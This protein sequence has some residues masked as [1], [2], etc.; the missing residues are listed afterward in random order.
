MEYQELIE[1]RQS[2]RKF[3]KRELSRAQIQEIRDFYE[4]EAGRLYP[5]IH[6]ELQVFTG[7][8]KFRL[9]GVAGYRGN[10]FFAPAYVV[11]FSEQADYYMENAGYITEDLILK[12]TDMELDNCWL[13]VPDAAAAKR[14]LDVQSD[15]EVVT[16]IACGYGKPE[17]A[18][19][20]LDI[21]NPANVDFKSRKGH[22]A[23]KISQHDLVYDHTWG[24]EM[25]WELSGTAPQ[26]D[27][28]FYAA[29]LAPSF[30][31]RQPYRFVFSNHLILLYVQKEEMTTEDDTRLD[32]GAVMFNFSAVYHEHAVQTHQWKCGEPAETLP[33][34]NAPEDYHLAAYFEMGR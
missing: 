19:T 12:L 27:H 17:F 20:R 26:F 18:L 8:A 24:T 5:E 10:C 28:A 32:L 25:N 9:E 6:T 29:S 2:I 14:A 22:I 13:T 7:D 23:P 3:K 15:L 11:L 30:L 16:I 21:K 4:F 34:V 33:E 31:N 1:E